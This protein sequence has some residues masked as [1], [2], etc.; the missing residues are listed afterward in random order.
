MYRNKKER[1]IEMPKLF[2][3]SDIHSFYDQMIDALTKAGFDKDNEDHWLIVCG[4]CFDRGPQ[5]IETLNYLQ[6]LPRK[7]L[8]KGNH[9]WLITECINRKY[10]LAHDWHNGTVRTIID[11][12]P[13]ARAL[14]EAYEIT[15]EKIKDFIDGMVNYF[16]TKHYVMVH[17]FI[18]KKRSWRKAT[19]REWH[20]AMW[21]NSMDEIRSRSIKKT[22]VAGHFHAS[23]GRKHYEGL[24]EWGDK[25]DFSPYYY[26]NK[27]IAIDGCT[28]YTGKCNVLV[29]EDEFL[30]EI[31]KEE[32]KNVDK[33]EKESREK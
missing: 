8:V 15:Q 31:R 1:E 14:E 10:P 19:Q 3:I 17:G 21:L 25:A 27:L 29:L 20:S 6:S 5:S 26:Q 16:E 22:I 11:M 30:D 24:P 33:P 7:V 18:P 13:E 32:A 2:C 28:A 23:W 4:D 9:E 12:A